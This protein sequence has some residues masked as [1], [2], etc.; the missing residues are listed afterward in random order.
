MKHGLS[1]VAMILVTLLVVRAVI[2]AVVN[3]GLHSY[4]EAF[5][6]KSIVCAVPTQRLYMAENKGLAAVTA[7]ILRSLIS[8]LLRG[9]HE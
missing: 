4:F 5:A 8:N 9:G 6:A 1:S 3:F 7:Q 2:A